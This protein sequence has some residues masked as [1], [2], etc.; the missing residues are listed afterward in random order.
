MK[1]FKVRQLNLDNNFGFQRV[2]GQDIGVDKHGNLAQGYQHH[3]ALW[4]KNN[5]LHLSKD[6]TVAHLDL[7]GTVDYFDKTF[8]NLSANIM[9]YIAPKTVLDLGCGCG[10]L[11]SMLRAHGVNTVTV[12]ANKDTINSPYI[13]ENHFIART[14]K[15][16]SFVDENNNSVIFDLVIS[17]EHFEHIP[18]DTMDRLITNVSKHTKNGSYFIFTAAGWAY[19]SDKSH[20]HCNVQSEASWKEYVTKYKFEIIQNLFPIGRGDNTA[21]IFSRSL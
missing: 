13:D 18:Q 19:D 6:K 17:L 20:I 5:D 7:D 10:Q 21:E 14:D 8:R 3:D 9:K 11:T 4:W 12:D 16:L 15:P 1:M 2:E